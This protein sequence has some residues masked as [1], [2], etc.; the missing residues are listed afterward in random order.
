VPRERRVPWGLLAGLAVAAAA[1]VLVVVT[2]AG[3]H[4]VPDGPVPVAWDHEPCGHCRMLVGE[5][6]HAAQL[7]TSDGEV[8]DFDDPGCL[9]HYLADR[10]P[11]VH[12]LWFHDSQSDRWLGPDQVRFRT[13]A[14]TPMGFGLA[15][16][17][18]GPGTLDLDAARALLLGGGPV[19]PAG[20]APSAPLSARDP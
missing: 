19:P 20:A 13:G 10:R 8:V 5:P 1:A 7:I 3:G 6:A 17:A 12:R 11:S 4:S 18:D 9:I 2:V 14:I 16:V 15:A